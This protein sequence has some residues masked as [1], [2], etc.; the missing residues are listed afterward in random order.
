MTD[1]A[2]PARP[3]FLLLPLAFVNFAVGAGAFLVIGLLSPLAQ[4][5]SMS[6]V[7]AGWVMS[8]YALGYAL[9][10]PLL[11]ALTGRLRRRTVLLTG[12]AIFV[13]ASV[14]SAIAPTP[15]FLYAARIL[16]AIG[17]G[18]TTP[19]A[20]AIAVATST[21]ATRG[22]ALSF[23]FAG[24]TIA[25][26][27][28]VP[29]GA[30]I[31]YT[32]GPS[33]AFILAA[34][35]CALVSIWV[36]LAVPSDVHFQPQSLAT[37]ARTILSPR[38]L[39]AVLLTVTIATSGYLGV[40]FMGPLAELRLGMGRDG[41]A[42]M[43]VAGG[44]GAFVGNVVAGRVTDRLGASRTLLLFLIAQALLLPAFTTIPYGLAL[45]LAISFCWNAA[46]WGFTVPQ[47]TRLMELDPTTQGVML[48][49]NAAGIYLGTG[50][51]S[52]IA[53]AVYEHWGIEATGIVGGAIA[54]LAIAHLLFSD[55]LAKRTA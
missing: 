38:H 26:V 9:T 44:V 16:A 18:M 28:G 47:Q 33:V 3:R 48:A 37:L 49:L 22:K 4:S 12:I 11:I 55:W 54:V 24:M 19:V 1:A 7:Q 32:Y 25:Q 30:F 2:V 43:L 39:V 20:A 34:V 10:S 50:L 27:V 51:G 6:K 35:L 46:G 29:A 40:T 14:L 53:G 36:A 31:G 45:G 52:A 21:E 23:V 15:G 17:S 42:L 8:A 41:V 13:V 5:L